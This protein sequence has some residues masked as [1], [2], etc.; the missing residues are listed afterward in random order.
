M[1]LLYNHNHRTGYSYQR[2]EIYFP[3]YP[4]KANVNVTSSW[5]MAIQHV[6]TIVEINLDFY[7]EEYST[8]S[9]SWLPDCFS[10]NRGQC[11]H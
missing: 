7:D 8:P 11:R 1:S 9:P 2:R 3:K 4:I 6:A 10:A 5:R